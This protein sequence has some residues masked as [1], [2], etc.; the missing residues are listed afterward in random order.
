MKTTCAILISFFTLS[1]ILAQS[2]IV[3]AGGDATSA[4]GSVSYS[5]GQIDFQYSSSADYSVSEGVQQTYS[6]DTALSIDDVKY[7]FQLSIW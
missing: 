5:I 7:D 6:F 2:N 3:T 4:T 1:S